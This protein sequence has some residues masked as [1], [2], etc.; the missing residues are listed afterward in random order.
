MDLPGAALLN[1]SL[2]KQGAP[3]SCQ[4]PTTNRQPRVSLKFGGKAQT[5]PIRICQ[6]E[7]TG[8]PRRAGQ[9]VRGN[10]PL[11]LEFSQA[12]RS[13]WN[14]EVHGTTNL[15]IASVLGEKDRLTLPSEL[16]EERE[17]RFEPMLPVDLE[18]ETIDVEAQAQRCV[19][20]AQL[21]NDCLWHCLMS[22]CLI[23]GTERP[24]SAGR[25][26]RRPA[27]KLSA[28]RW[29]RPA[30]ATGWASL[31]GDGFPNSDLREFQVFKPG[32]DRY[33]NVPMGLHFTAGNLTSNL[34]RK[35]L[36]IALCVRQL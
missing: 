11:L 5:V 29:R 36:E 9:L 14:D 13:V 21:G 16:D 15:A 35:R 34:G 1:D 33:D 17:A 18:A 24:E 4:L 3:A 22:F 7:L 2:E 6:Q 31:V 20:D 30:R 8:S 28:A 25:A 19:G 12:M 27:A 26:Q 10:N 32:C 23:V